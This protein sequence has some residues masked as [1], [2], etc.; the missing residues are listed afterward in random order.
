MSRDVVR[1]AMS[2]ACSRSPHTELAGHVADPYVHALCCMVERRHLC[3]GRHV[4]LLETG[5]PASQAARAVA[6]SAESPWQA[7]R[8]RRVDVVGTNAAGA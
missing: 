4:Y 1:V 7:T 8:R 5:L 3:G 2:S 6:A